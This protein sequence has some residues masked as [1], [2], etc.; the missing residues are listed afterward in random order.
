MGASK[1]ERLM[2]TREY[3]SKFTDHWRRVELDDQWKDMIEINRFLMVC[4][5]ALSISV[6]L[7]A[8]VPF[9]QV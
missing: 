9:V 8:R 2:K 4:R 3:F 7:L 6:P 1:A 5:G